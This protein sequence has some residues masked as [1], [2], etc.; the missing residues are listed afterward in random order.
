MQD[1]R[2]IQFLENN[3]TIY[4]I[5]K[6]S[7]NE[8]GKVTSFDQE[9]AFVDGD[10]IE[11]LS[12]HVIHLTSALTKPIIDAKMLEELVIDKDAMDKYQQLMNMTKNVW[13][14]Y[15]TH[16]FLLQVFAPRSDTK[17]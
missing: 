1:Y 2:V 9:P 6:V 13:S 10:S 12:Y 15:K 14:R 16:R 8:Q 11:N 5:H 4:R 3:K 17:A 7:Y